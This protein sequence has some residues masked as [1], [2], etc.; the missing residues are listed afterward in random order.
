MPP[1]I[2][3]H[4]D[5]EECCLLYSGHYYEKACVLKKPLSREIITSLQHKLL[6]QLYKS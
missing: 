5:F 6:Q 2:F 3:Y 4:I 1:L